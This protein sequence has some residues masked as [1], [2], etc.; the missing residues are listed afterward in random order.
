M[1]SNTLS[2][3]HAKPAQPFLPLAD[4]KVLALEVLLVQVYFLPTN[5]H[6]AAQATVEGRTAVQ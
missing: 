1:W 2:K 5:T 6:A 3:T 4:E